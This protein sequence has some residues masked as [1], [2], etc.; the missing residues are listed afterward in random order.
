MVAMSVM[1]MALAS[2]L[3]I[4][5]TVMYIIRFLYFLRIGVLPVIYPESTS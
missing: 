5:E 2:F 3:V 4:F 1:V